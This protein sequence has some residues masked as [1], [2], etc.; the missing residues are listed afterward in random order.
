MRTLYWML[1]VLEWGRR[2]RRQTNILFTYVPVLVYLLFLVWGGG[3]EYSNNDPRAY[4]I[5]LLGFCW[6]GGVSSPYTGPGTGATRHDFSHPPQRRSPDRALNRSGGSSSLR[7]A[8]RVV[9]TWSS[10][11]QRL[12]RFSPPAL[13]YPSSLRFSASLA[14]LLCF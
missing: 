8:F 3:A 6:G 9:P 4:P 5:V 11:L 12:D 10:Y 2:R 1:T 14:A 7:P 13:I